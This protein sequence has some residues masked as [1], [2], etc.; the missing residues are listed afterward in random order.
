M[1]FAASSF[2]RPRLWLAG[3]ALALSLVVPAFARDITPDESQA[4]SAAVDSFNTA[5]TGNDFG[6]LAQTIPPKLFSAMAAQNN[7]D[8]ATLRQAL[9]A[10]MQETLSQVKIAKFSM[11]LDAAEHKEGA[12]GEPF[13]LIPTV[14][15]IEMNG[16]KVETDSKTLGLLDGGKWY[17]LRVDPSQVVLIKQVYPALADVTFDPGTTKAV[18]E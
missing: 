11:D 7:L 10:Q 6:T 8:E 9:T 5:M 14:T 12:D 15:V 2:Y 4:L 16:S 13:V 3:A 1:R 17:L 18:N